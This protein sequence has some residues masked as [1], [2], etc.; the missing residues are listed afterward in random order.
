MEQI[1][2]DLRSVELDDLVDRVLRASCAIASIADRSMSSQVA[3]TVPQFRTLAALGDR[4]NQSLR[5]LA[6]E[7]GVDASTASRTCDRLVRRHLVRRDVLTGNRRQVT[8][9][10]TADGRRVLTSLMAARRDVIRQVV[11]DVPEPV[12]G[13]VAEAL[14]VIADGS[15]A[16]IGRMV[17]AGRGSP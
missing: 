17:R 14:Q 4:E 10:L 1:T 8:L 2:G 9:E 15:R 6:E 11:A 16:W 5:Q 7:I 12:R 3:M 13:L